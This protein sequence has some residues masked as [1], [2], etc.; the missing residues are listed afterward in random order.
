MTST[1]SQ[2]RKFNIHELI[3]DLEEN[4]ILN[5]ISMTL[6]ILFVIRKIAEYAK[7]MPVQPT[8]LTAPVTHEF[9]NALI[10][11]DFFSFVLIGALFG[12]IWFINYCIRV[13]ARSFYYIFYKAFR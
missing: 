3:D 8:N 6:A 10:G 11:T 5:F 12:Y 2:E 13:I 9:L 4:G 1:K 7:H